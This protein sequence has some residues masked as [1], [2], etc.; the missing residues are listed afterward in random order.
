MHNFFYRM[1]FFRHIQHGDHHHDR[2]FAQGNVLIALLQKGPVTQNELL[3]IIDNERPLVNGKPPSEI[4]SELEKMK[5]IKRENNGEDKRGDIFSLTKK[6]EMLANRLQI[7]YRFMKNMSESFSDE[8][9]E[10]FTAILEKLHP[11]TNGAEYA[12][13]HFRGSH[14]EFVD[15]ENK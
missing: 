7:H 13:F 6:G 1:K 9:K 4:L 2:F 8:E 14:S 3:E 12:H 15:R 11:N 10:Q 5:F